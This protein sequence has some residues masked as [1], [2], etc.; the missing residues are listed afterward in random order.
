MEVAVCLG[1]LVEAAARPAFGLAEE[2][3]VTD[4]WEAAERALAAVAALAVA[5]LAE[6]EAAGGAV[7]LGCVV[8]A[9]DEDAALA[10]LVAAV[11]ALTADAATG[12][13]SSEA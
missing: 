10:A 7:A 2:V 3:L 4:G 11:A 1:R 6:N 12:A 5:A 8:K 13:D 9:K